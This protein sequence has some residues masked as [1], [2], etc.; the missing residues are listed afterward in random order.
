[1]IAI[2]PEIL[3]RRLKQSGEE[4]LGVWKRFSGWIL[5][6]SWT[7]GRI[8]SRVAN[9]ITSYTATSCQPPWAVVYLPFISPFWQTSRGALR[10]RRL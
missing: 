10:Q 2:A 4:P 5:G 9:L 7:L 1:M 3:E 6:T 8:T